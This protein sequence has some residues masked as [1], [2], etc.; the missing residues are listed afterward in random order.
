MDIGKVPEAVLK[1]AVIGKAG[2]CKRNEVM[3]GSAVGEDCAA[4]ELPEG[5]IFVMGDNR[6]GSLDSR[7]NE[8]GLIPVENI[9]GKAEIRIYPFS[10]FGSVY[11]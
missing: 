2:S 4:L 11:E 7:S 5:Y 10:S 8:I 9:I 6:E 1:R 3:M